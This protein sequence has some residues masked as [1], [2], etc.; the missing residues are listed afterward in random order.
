MIFNI[1]VYKKNKTYGVTFVLSPTHN[2]DLLLFF[3]C[4]T[5][6]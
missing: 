6:W 4:Q 3:I 1:V 5:P 2:E